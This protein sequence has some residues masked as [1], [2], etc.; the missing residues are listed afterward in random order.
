MAE[1]KTPPRKKAA[2][3]KPSE[4]LG[5]VLA[6]AERKQAADRK[7]HWKGPRVDGVTSSLLS[8]FLVCRHRFYVKAIEGWS[9]HDAFNHR[10]EYGNMFH[11]CDEVDAK[12]PGTWLN[13]LKRECQR[14]QKKYPSAVDQIAKWG[15]VCRRQ[16]P[17]YLDH[18]RKLG[19]VK[20]TPV[21]SEHAFLVPYTTRNGNTVVLR[22]KMDGMELGTEEGQ[23]VE[24]SREYLWVKESKTK[25]EIDRR[26]IERRL[27]FDLQTN[28]YLTALKE[29]PKPRHPRRDE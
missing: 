24:N 28:F 19:Y 11:A 8:R 26:E 25:S 5:N 29:A 22:G 18:W 10:I 23:E 9:P 21:W 7:V 6:E 3:P 1:T 16:Y 14:L 15:E 12:V 17:I 13:G 4:S 2:S 27:K 20:P